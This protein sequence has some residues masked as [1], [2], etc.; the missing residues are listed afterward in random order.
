MPD[1]LR[2]PTYDDRQNQMLALKAIHLMNREWF[3]MLTVP[4]PDRFLSLLLL[5]TYAYF[6]AGSPLHKK[7]A[8]KQMGLETIKTGRKYIAEAERLG[9]I[10]IIPSKDDRRR[11]LLYPTDALIDVAGKALADFAAEV[12]TLMDLLSSSS[13]STTTAG[14]GEEARDVPQERLNSPYLA[15]HEQTLYLGG[16]PF[17]F[18]AASDK[19]KVKLVRQ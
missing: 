1:N 5:S 18:R 12:L 4:A 7:A 14:I 10:K 11:E 3:P 2:P 13:V 16:T 17:Y 15:S 9:L 6:K 19:K 8:W